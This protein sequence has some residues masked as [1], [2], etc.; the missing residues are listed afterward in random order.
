MCA[1]AGNYARRSSYENKPRACVCVRAVSPV[2]AECRAACV[3]VG[4]AGALYSFIIVFTCTEMRARMS[5]ARDAAVRASAGA[6][7]VARSVG[8]R[9][10]VVTRRDEV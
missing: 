2:R 1:R 4:L 9:V 5:G 6:R 8:V 10:S 7:A 3:R